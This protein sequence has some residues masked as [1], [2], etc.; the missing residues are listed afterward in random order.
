[1]GAVEEHDLAES[2]GPEPSH[3]R[4]RGARRGGRRSR[5]WAWVAV[6][7]ALVVGGVVA[8]PPGGVIVGTHTGGVELGVLDLD[9]RDAPVQTW[10][11]ALTST[12]EGS[13]VLRVL[14]DVVITAGPDAV[15]GH[16]LADGS[17]LWRVE[18]DRLTC[19]SN[20]VLVC[21]D[22]GGDD[23]AEVLRID[24]RSGETDRTTYPRA[25]AAVDAGEDLVVLR[26]GD[27]VGAGELER[28][29]PDGAVRWAIDRWEIVLQDRW[30]GVM[31]VIGDQLQV[32]GRAIDLGTG[33][34]FTTA[35]RWWWYDGETQGRVVQVDD[36]GRSL[37]DV[38]RDGEVVARAQD[39]LVAPDDD[40][41]GLLELRTTTTDGVDAVGVTR[42][43]SGEVLWT[44]GIDA[45]PAARLE[46]VVVLSRWTDPEE[47][48]LEGRDVRTGELLW[49]A[50]PAPSIIGGSGSTLLVHD[51]TG[52]MSGLDVRTGQVRWTSDVDGFFGTRVVT[53]DGMVV[54][55]GQDLVRLDW[56]RR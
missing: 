20:R 34:E 48:T 7:A 45:Y 33:E 4:A 13:E 23:D 32:D 47:G 41:G 37:L 2:R 12:L 6:A 50:G 52:R 42:S 27:L 31:S 5:P 54:V 3:P 35:D 56:P 44:A 28:R 10:R 43:D 39:L 16:D 14:G 9:L 21:V 55:S 25:R 24:A 49:T 40:L 46:G 11:T 29:A 1:M 22:G 26:S 30:T 38:R 19:Q 36:A 53:P 17:L 8:A 51:T 15:T 18:G